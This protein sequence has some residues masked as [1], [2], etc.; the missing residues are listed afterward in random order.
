MLVKSGY[1][2]FSLVLSFWEAQ[3]IWKSKLGETSYAG[4][5]KKEKPQSWGDACEDEQPPIFLVLSHCGTS[6]LRT[7]LWSRAR[8]KS[9]MAKWLEQASQW[10]E[11]YCHDLEVMS[12]NP[13][14]VELGVLGT[15]A[16]SC[17]WIKTS[18]IFFGPEPVHVPFWTEHKQIL[19]F[20]VYNS[21]I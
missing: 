5:R 2:W 16:L 21:P 17:T 15:S 11:M 3:C 1:P 18:L 8:I 10:H 13:G 19:F 4:V 12:S 6:I 9:L 7:C 20:C 14:R